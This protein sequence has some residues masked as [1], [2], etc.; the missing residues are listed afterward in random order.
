MMKLAIDWIEFAVKFV[1][2]ILVHKM[3]NAKEEIINLFAH[4][5]QVYSEIHM[6]NARDNLMCHNVLPIRIAQLHWL[7]WI[8]DVKIHV[9][10]LMFVIHNKHVPS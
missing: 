7:V 8:D 1:I 9:Q 10:D 5:S 3:P 6:L 2:W 4:V